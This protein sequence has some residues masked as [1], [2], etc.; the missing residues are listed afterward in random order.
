MN[1]TQPHFMIEEGPERG[2]EIVVPPEGARMGRATEND[3]SIA[4]AAMSRFQCR[5][6]FRDGFLHVMDLGSTNETL[7]NDQPVSDQALR[8]GDQIWIGDSLLRVVKDGLGENR[9]PAEQSLAPEAEAPIVFK[10]EPDEQR[11]APVPPPAQSSRPEP[12]VLPTP[13]SLHPEGELDLGLGKQRSGSVHEDS[14]ESPAK[15]NYL[16]I[17]LV[18]I[19][20]VFLVG[21]VYLM[22]TPQANRGGSAA[23][24]VNERTLAV[25][26]ERVR[27]GE[28]N[29]YRFAVRIQPDGSVYA[30]VHDLVNEHNIIRE[31]QAS[32]D[33]FDRLTQQ[34]LDRREGFSRLRG[35][36][37]GVAV[38]VHEATEI[39]L[40]TGADI[41]TV[42]VSNHVEPPAF[43]GMKD[44]IIAW[45]ENE[46][47]LDN[48][49][50]SPRELRE[51]ADR[52]WQNAQRLHNE[53][54]VKNENLWQ[55]TQQ[56]REMIWLVDTLEPKPE[57]YRQGLELRD[58][59]REELE[60]RVRNMRF[61]AAREYQV[62]NLNRALEIYRRVLA[63]FPEQSSTLYQQ[64]FTN[65]IQLE[66]ELRRR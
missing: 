30:E 55:A 46:L 64:T 62:G 66:Q 19:L 11:P 28:G 43:E 1:P 10:T 6:Y 8:H 45:V 49:S 15:T 23:A 26:L 53:R 4:D 14:N 61:E 38:D 63:T 50:R 2:R 32:E 41:R 54:D 65:I 27:A 59:W 42:R 37:E 40:L 20:L 51:L 57:Y 44:Q 24:A 33:S 56:L 29:I 47:N 22:L 3:I 58:Q 16:L 52:A 17:T 34:I 39:T 31:H 48:L 21:L 12:N 13:E 9:P 35:D 60:L 25:N 7:V 18:T 5:V 36:Y